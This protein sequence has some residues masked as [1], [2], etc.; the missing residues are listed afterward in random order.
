MYFKKEIETYLTDFLLLRLARLASVCGSSGWASVAAMT[1]PS[2]LSEPA[3]EPGPSPAAT[4]RK[5][6]KNDAFC[7]THS[8]T[9]PNTCARSW[10]NHPKF[11][12]HWTQLTAKAYMSLRNPIHHVHAGVLSVS[13]VCA[14]KV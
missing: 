1:G 14:C 2:W 8:V 9:H 4:S 3:R 6:S 5:H 13:T 7:T 10:S 11:Q 12:T